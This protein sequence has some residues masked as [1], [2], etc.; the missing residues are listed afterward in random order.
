MSESD[1]TT[2]IEDLTNDLSITTRLPEIIKKAASQKK[3]DVKKV[4][5]PW[6]D[7][8]KILHEF[9][10]NNSS[11]GWMKL[12]VA[13]RNNDKKKY[14]RLRKF[15]QNFNINSPEHLANIVDATYDGAKFLGW[16]KGDGSHLLKL[17]NKIKALEESDS[18]KNERIRELNEKVFDLRLRQLNTQ[19]PK[20]K[21]DLADFKK[22][23]DGHSLENKL[24][25]FL[26]DHTWL[27][28]LEY[29]EKQPISFNQFEL[30]DS[31]FDFLL[32]RY[33]T[34]Y[35][36][37]EIKTATAPLLVGDEI[38]SSKIDSTTR[39]SPISAELKNAISQIIG[40]L[41]LTNIH[42]KDLRKN[43]II[44]HKPKGKIV[45]GRSKGK[46]KPVIRTINSYLNN[47]EIMT[48]DDLLLTSKEFVTR[49]QGRHLPT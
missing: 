34:F 45:I 12:T 11:G 8:N 29:V 5:L 44:L 17:V 35:D 21:K 36:I 25:E 9:S 2:K 39:K 32:Q 15:K 28:G 46:V 4:I 18:K 41:E 30:S 16:K 13:E 10:I 7:S 43:G 38:D 20:F 47:I 31:R 3:T 19:I 6:K 42:S 33:D 24:Q 40:Y 37:F 22:L 49:I 26:E 27:F 14:L 1:K 48:Y 23:L